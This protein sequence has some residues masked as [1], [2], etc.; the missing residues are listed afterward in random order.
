MQ[1]DARG[2]Q[3]VVHHDKLKPYIGEQGLPWAR[4]ALRAHKTRAKWEPLAHRTQN[5][6]MRVR[7]SSCSPHRMTYKCSTCDY[8]SQ[9]YHEMCTHVLQTIQGEGWPLQVW[10]LWGLQGDSGHILHKL[11]EELL[12][13]DR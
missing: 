12:G 6:E 4:S 2:K 1:L 13:A 5:D 7:A 11:Q 10:S 8:A 9:L 3:M